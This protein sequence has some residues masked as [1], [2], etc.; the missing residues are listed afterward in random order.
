MGAL[1]I[2]CFAPICEILYGHSNH[3]RRNLEMKRAT[4]EGGFEGIEDGTAVL[5]P[6]GADRAD[7]AE[8]ICADIAAERARHLLLDFD[9]A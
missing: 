2:M 6:G 9:H 7:A 5:A 4:G 8:G 1:H 3:S